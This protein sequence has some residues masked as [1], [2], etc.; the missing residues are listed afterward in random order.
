M[1]SSP[2]CRQKVYPE[3]L[4]NASVIVVYYNEAWSQILRTVHSVVN[5]IPPQYL[6]EVILLDDSSTRPELGGGPVHQYVR[7][8]WPDGIVKI[9]RTPKRIGL[10]NARLAGA[11]AA[12]GDVI[13]FLDAHCE[14]SNGWL[15]SR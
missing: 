2:R 12:T 6:H 3:D 4:P 1:H 13:M 7:D 15:V 14:M 8:T 5:C 9:V 11:E 10:I